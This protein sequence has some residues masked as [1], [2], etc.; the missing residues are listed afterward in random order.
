MGWD[1][2]LKLMGLACACMQSDRYP[3]CDM[4]I[5][6]PHVSTVFKPSKHA[7]AQA[8]HRNVS[9]EETSGAQPF[10]TLGHQSK[11]GGHQQSFAS[12]INATFCRS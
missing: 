6:I 11:Q 9:L 4:Y 2:L 7:H 12:A 3:A 1:G 5:Y 10:S 8:R